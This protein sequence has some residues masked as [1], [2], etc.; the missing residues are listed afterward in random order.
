MPPHC[1]VAQVENVFF[2]IVEIANIAIII[3][4]ALDS[5]V[6]DNPVVHRYTKIVFMY[7]TLHVMKT[8]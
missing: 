6:F 4:I 3:Y 2:M 8:V 1:F 5:S 7:I